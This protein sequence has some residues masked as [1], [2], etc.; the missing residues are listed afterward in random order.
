MRNNYETIRYDF[1]N[2]FLTVTQVP[3][4]I[5]IHRQGN[6]GATALHALN[7]GNSTKAFTIHSYIGG[8]RCYDAIDPRRH[9]FHVKEYRRAATLGFASNGQ[10][11]RRGDYNS[12]GIEAEDVRG[13]APGQAYSLTQD[14]R[15]TLVLRV[16][17]YCR[18]FNISPMR[19]YEHADLDP[20]T[21]SEDLGD[22]LN[23][24]DFRQDVADVL[25]GRTPWRTVGV[26]ATG[27]RNTSPPN[28]VVPPSLPS[29]PPASPGPVVPI[30]DVDIALIYDD[31]DATGKVV[32]YRGTED[33]SSGYVD[34][35]YEVRLRTAR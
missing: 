12:I 4:R 26:H 35:V 1:S 7:W 32:S 23:V 34:R 29:A 5:V 33:V 2:W 17:A 18:E 30:S 6:P 21:R 22:A 20:W 24:G 25:A 8:K 11:G 16:A 19:I 27:A 9:A 15:I 14:T 13:G 3:D 28:V 10:Y 31:R